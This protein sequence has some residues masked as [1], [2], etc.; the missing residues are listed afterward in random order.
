M[1]NNTSEKNIKEFGSCCG[2]NATC[3]CKNK[4]T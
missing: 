1:E 3:V 4:N 2:H